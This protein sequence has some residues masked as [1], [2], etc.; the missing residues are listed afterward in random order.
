MNI[1]A[2]EVPPAKVPKGGIAAVFVVYVLMR[3]I[4]FIFASK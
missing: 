2:K 1:G 3:C 4:Q